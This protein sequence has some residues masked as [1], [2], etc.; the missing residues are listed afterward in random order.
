VSLVTQLEPEI[1]Q[2]MLE[3]RLPVADTKILTAF[4]SVPAGE[5]RITLAKAM[6]EGKATAKMVIQTCRRYNEARGA[7]LSRGRKRKQEHEQAKQPTLAQ[8]KISRA[9]PE[10]DALY[11]LGKVPPWPVVTEAVMATCDSCPIRYMASP[12]ICSECAM[13]TAL[14]KMME[15]THVS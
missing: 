15:A 14:Q 3:R 1:Q 9:H 8:E 12:A 13:V 2:L 7:V 11:Q 5:E 4:L 6:A 10:W